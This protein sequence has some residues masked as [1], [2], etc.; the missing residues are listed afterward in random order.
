MAD[1]NTGQRQ[2][3]QARQELK[4]FLRIE[5]A[6]VLEMSE[7]EFQRLIISLKNNPLF[8]RLHERDRIIRYQPL[9]RSDLSHSFYEVKEEIAASP[10]SF[11]VESLISGK[12]QL[13]GKIKALGLDKFKKYFL[14]PEAGVTEEEIARQCQ[15]DVTEVQ[16]I[17]EL[18]DELSV[19]TEF[20][21]TT[22]VPE[23]RIYYSKV[24]SVEETSDGFVIA[25]FSPTHARGKFVVDYEK[26]EQL[27]KAG[28]FNKAEIKE[29]RQLFQK[30]E[31][32]NNRKDTL[33]RVLLGIGEKQ[34]LFLKSGNPKALLPFTQKELATKTGLAIS[35]VSRAIS[36]KSID[37]PWGERPLKDFFPRPK[38]FRKEL[39]KQLLE[40]EKKPISD[41]AIK[42]KLEE[43]FGV[44]LSRRTIASLRKELRIPS[45]RQRKK[46]LAKVI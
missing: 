17:N 46:S 11:D 31:L 9:P 6:N 28:V 4:L 37:T 19:A 24:A 12:A 3:V 30:L 1:V 45:S 40:K 38:K 20:Y 7:D 25:Y 35:S 39:V 44:S 41:R 42:V 2:S 43:D 10:G 21:D 16:K 34:A 22:A 33:H 36:G 14:Y 5:Q 23:R 32:I 29:I 15:L 27:L 26:F 18:I 13:I 8:K